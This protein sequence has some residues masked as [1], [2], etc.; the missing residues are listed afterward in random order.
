MTQNTWLK[1][2]CLLALG[3]PD[4][5]AATSGLD[6]SPQGH[7]VM[8]LLS[9]AAGLILSELSPTLSSKPARPSRRRS[10]TKE[11]DDVGPQRYPTS[12]TSR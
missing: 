4:L 2:S 10:V 8:A 1:I 12:T 11:N 6:I 9:L 5:A 7:F 3:V